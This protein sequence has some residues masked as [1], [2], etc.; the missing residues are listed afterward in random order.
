[1]PGAAM[2]HPA[3]SRV[4]ASFGVMN[5]PPQKRLHSV[6][7]RPRN[8]FPRGVVVFMGGA[9]SVAAEHGV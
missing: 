3:A 7:E 5:N 2:Q 1:M 8:P 4:N 9:I 6:N